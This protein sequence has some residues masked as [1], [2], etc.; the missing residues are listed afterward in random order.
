MKAIARR[1]TAACA[2]QLDEAAHELVALRYYQRFLDEA[3]RT[4]TQGAGGR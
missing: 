4:A 2:A 1:S 3:S